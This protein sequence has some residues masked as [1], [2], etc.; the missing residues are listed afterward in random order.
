M[1]VDKDR[2]MKAKEAA[3]R[4]A[5]ELVQDGM[6]VGLGTGSTAVC[7]IDHLALRV[8]DGLRIQAV[9]T[10]QASQN[11]AVQK[12]IPILDINDVLSIDL[13]VDGVDQI[14]PQKQMIKGAGGALLREKIVAYMSREM[15]VV[16]DETKLV[17]KLGGHRVPVEIV[18]FAYKATQ[19][20]LARNGY[21]GEV[22]MKEKSPYVTDNN[23]YIIDVKLPDECDPV[24]AH[25]EIK[26][27]PGVVESGLFLGMAGRIIIGFDNGNFEIRE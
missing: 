2:Y 24:I 11:Y 3:G 4:A 16:L 10:S 20:Y 12:R 21:R 27:I 25:A 9:A 5:A 22:R 8:R 6:I 23:N 26:S 18:P 13:T 19:F 1:I 7:F 14:D 15:I 17:P